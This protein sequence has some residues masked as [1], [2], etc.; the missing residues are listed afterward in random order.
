MPLVGKLQQSATSPT[1]SP[2]QNS[3][4]KHEVA[5]ERK[6]THLVGRDARLNLLSVNIPV[7]QF[8]FISFMFSQSL[9][10][11]QFLEH[12]GLSYVLNAHVC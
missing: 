10:L 5:R 8:F 6:H 7:N 2:E 9:H 1:Y 11:T 4:A 12:N 3:G